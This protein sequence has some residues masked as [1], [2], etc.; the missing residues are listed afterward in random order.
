MFFSNGWSIEKLSGPTWEIVYQQCP[1]VVKVR[2]SNSL[3]C[4]KKILFITIRRW[5]DTAVFA[6]LE[7]WQH[8]S[9]FS[10]KITKCQFLLSLS[11]KCISKTLVDLFADNKITGDNI[12]QKSTEFWILIW[13]EESLHNL[14]LNGYEIKSKIQKLFQNRDWKDERVN[15][16]TFD[17]CNV[18]VFTLKFTWNSSLGRNKGAAIVLTD[19]V[20][21]W[22][23]SA[24]FNGLFLKDEL[25]V[26]EHLCHVASTSCSLTIIEVQGT[27]SSC[28]MMER[29]HLT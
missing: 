24:I 27:G 17:G 14:I 12:W 25:V 5:L 26:T 9:Y 28:R 18:V 29:K 20:K 2:Y 3:D 16:F 1:L 7:Y 8:F 22:K 11:F 13:L 19:R 6:S 23:S 10:T 4:K 15:T 21:W